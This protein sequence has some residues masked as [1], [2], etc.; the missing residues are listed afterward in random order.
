MIA[1]AVAAGSR[2]AEPAPYPNRPIRVI[3]PFTAG[4]GT[5]VTTRAVAQ[6]L[7]PRLGQP[8]VVENR[9]G[10][11]AS[12][13][14]AVVKN[15]VPDGYTLLVGTATLI[16]NM[17]VS[18]PSEN[19]DP[20]KDFEFIGKVGQIDLIA[21]VN[22]KS[23][24]RTLDDLVQRMRAQPGRVSWGSPGTGAP[25]HLGGELLKQ[26]TGADALH[27]PYKGE[28][29][30]VTDLL[31]GVI[32]FVLCSPNVCVPRIQDGALRGLAVAAKRRSRMA[33]AIPTSAEAGVAGLEAG[34][35][36]YLAAPRKTPAGA[37]AR[38]NAALN[39]V[40]ADEKFRNRMLEFGVEIEP[41]TTPAGVAAAMQAEMEKWRPVVRAAGIRQ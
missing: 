21:M 27:V 23:D 1:L 34:T 20:V 10:A 26:I 5:D 11:S 39:E 28:S 29:A 32:T 37:I 25:G 14:A 18:G 24:I 22:G 40:Y 12:L 36:Y 31:G 9:A 13:G 15:A 17:L 41:G 4:G 19:V 7:A 6:E 16:T 2:A 38:V 3:V 35:W 30:A 33:P 8:I